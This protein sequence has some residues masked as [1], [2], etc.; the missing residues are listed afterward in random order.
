MTFPVVPSAEEPVSPELVLVDSDLALR[1][2]A[3][4]P[5]TTST[6]ELIGARRATVRREPER[7]LVAPP[8]FAPAADPA[9]AAM[10]RLAERELESH[11]LASRQR[12]R[13]RRR[14]SLALAGAALVASTI[15]GV[16]VVGQS[17]GRIAAH[18]VSTVSSPVARVVSHALP[19][20]GPVAPDTRRG[21]ATVGTTAGSRGGSS[22]VTSGSTSNRAKSENR[23][24]ST[25]VPV[26]PQSKIT[27]P[28]RPFIW[29]PRRG[30]TGYH[31]ELRRENSPIFTADSKTNR[32]V[33]PGTWRFHGKTRWLEP[34][35]RLYVWPVVEHA[36]SSI[37]VIAG[38][39]VVDLP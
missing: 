12:A 10:R 22:Q 27:W 2:R 5:E 30:A 31:V 35:D 34:D 24:L 25:F 18:A 39:L 9:V 28:T 4:L 15:L 37:A 6:L 13:S 7:L 21:A 1:A 3:G 33:V 26:K 29:P 20:S 16:T 8:L 19:T 11:E 38:E 23:D 14:L 36:R 32:V 17:P